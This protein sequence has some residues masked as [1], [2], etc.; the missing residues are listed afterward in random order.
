MSEMSDKFN[1]H[2]ERRISEMRQ[3]WRESKSSYK[4]KYRTWI[5]DLIGFN[6]W[7]INL[8]KGKLV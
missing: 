4:R 8:I 3:R 6:K 2:K 1:L 7:D 5:V